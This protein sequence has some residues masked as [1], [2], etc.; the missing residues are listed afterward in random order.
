MAARNQLSST[1][2]RA[3]YWREYRRR[4]RKAAKKKEGKP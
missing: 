2:P 3:K 1:H 4:V